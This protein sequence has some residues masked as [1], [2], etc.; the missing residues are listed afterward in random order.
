M[1]KISRLEESD[2]ESLYDLLSDVFNS[3]IKKDLLYGLI[4]NKN[5]I[6]LVCRIDNKIV[7]HAMVEIMRDFF[8]G[9]DYFFLNYF[10]VLKEYRCHG[11]GSLLIYELEKIAL[12]NNIDFMRFTSGNKRVDAHKFYKNR[13]YIIRDTSV[14]IKYFNCM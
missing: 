2:I 9:E 11:I 5:V 8:T 10:C 7:G 1:Y 3:S 13:G 12:E 6:D 14:F 4:D